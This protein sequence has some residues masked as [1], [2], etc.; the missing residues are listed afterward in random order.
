MATTV[1]LG[2]ATTAEAPSAVS[3]PSRGLF[4]TA[5]R[6][7]LHDRLTLTAGALLLLYAI[8]AIGAEVIA[9]QVFNTTPTK[10]DM[11]SVVQ[12]PSAAHWLGTDEFGR[13]QLVRLL[14][15]ARVSLTIGL[16]AAM[17]NL[18]L[19]VLL[20]AMAGFYGGRVD[21]AIVW[22]IN[23]LRAVPNLFLLILIGALFRIG[24]EALALVIGLISWPG[25]ARV[26][27][28]QMLSARERDYVLAAQ[29][30]GAN[31]PRVIGRHLLPNVLP[32]AL[33]ILGQDIGAVV[34]LES[35]LSY[36]GL[37]VQ[38]PTASWGNMLTNA[39]RYF[40]SGVWLVVAPGW[41]IFSTVLALYLVADGLRDALDPRLK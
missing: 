31:N 29:A 26:M 19:G 38:P 25:I 36:L 5:A 34:L 10:I 20:G 18:S 33:I 2:R 27:R 17:I 39:Q 15:G 7:I 22:L 13:D 35:A 14:Y 1:T 6:R 11:R 16:T 4:A 32:I 8:L 30:L 23:T 9:T 37:G 12:P 24:P 41:F 40:S 28:G 21:D 3:R